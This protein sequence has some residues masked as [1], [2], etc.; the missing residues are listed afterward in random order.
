MCLRSRPCTEDLHSHV[1][2][3]RIALPVTDAMSLSHCLV[4]TTAPRLCRQM[5]CLLLRRTHTEHD[6][7]PEW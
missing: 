2:A 5:S 1:F 6:D 4:S 7:S 3:E